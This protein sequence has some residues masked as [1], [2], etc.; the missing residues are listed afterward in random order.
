MEEMLEDLGSSPKSATCSVTAGK[1]LPLPEP[2]QLESGTP[3]GPHLIGAYDPRALTG[4]TVK[5][6]PQTW[7]RG[8]YHCRSLPSLWASG[9]VCPT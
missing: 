3:G 5:P 7:L 6:L 4:L 8:G 1:F 9:H 2:L